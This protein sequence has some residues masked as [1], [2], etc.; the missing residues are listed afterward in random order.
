MSRK[1]LYPLAFVVGLIMV[2]FKVAV[3]PAAALTDDQAIAQLKTFNQAFTA[4]AERV[5]PSVVTV[6]TK[7][8]VEA[9]RQGRRAPDFIHPFWQFP[10]PEEEQKRSG[11]GSGIIISREGY[12]LTNNHVIDKADEITVVMSDNREYTAELIGKDELTD[13][14][15]I[16]IEA[17][18]LIPV[19]VGNSDN[20]KIGEWV[21]AI[22]APLD[23]RSTVTSGIV[24]AIGRSLNII[25]NQYSVENFIQ[26]DAA[27]NPG[28]SGGALVS[29][30]GHLIGVNTA[31]ATSN[32]GFV[33]YGFAIPINLAK[34]VMDDIIE[35]GKVQRG[36]LGVSLQTVTARQA[37]AFGLDRPRGVLIDQV[38][39]NSPAERSDIKSGD[40]VLEVDGHPVDRPNALQSAIARKHPD[41]PVTLKVRRRTQ[42][43]VIKVKLGTIPETDDVVA[44][45]DSPPESAT[46]DGL[47]LTVHDITPEMA[48]SFGLEGGT[49]GVVVVKVAR[50][51]GRDAGF[52]RGDVIVGVRQG[53]VDLAIGH[54]SDFREAF[55]Q[56]EKGRAAAFSV[57]RRDS[58]RGTKRYMF[59]T[60]R[61]P[62]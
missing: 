40:I 10:Q 18:D 11:L 39:G 16:K 8:T 37:D 51:P 1:L 3:T 50:G 36:Y 53:D 7:Q 25:E 30:D 42:D 4:I 29:L 31:I 6:S 38:L 21:L 15:V 45:R 23:L 58:R 59:L 57:L 47:G 12:I 20:V 17:E 62:D 2:S 61:I 19:R 56:L 27:I 34:K 9:E 46:E 28:N 43:L 33:G 32:R 44:H 54:V 48:E 55:G 26:T 35:H 14:A 5:T 49:E 41:D 60:P 22:G 24:S 52:R 13:V